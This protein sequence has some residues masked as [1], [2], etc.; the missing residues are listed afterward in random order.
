MLTVFRVAAQKFRMSLIFATELLDPNPR[1]PTDQPQ[2]PKARLVASWWLVR[3]AK[4]L[5]GEHGCYAGVHLRHHRLRL[6][7]QRRERGAHQVPRARA[8]LPK[9][10]VCQSIKRSDKRAIT[11]MHAAGASRSLSTRRRSRKERADRHKAI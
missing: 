6:D 8:F 5:E 1:A 7:H 11:N 2:I 10:I 4:E 9:Q 3:T